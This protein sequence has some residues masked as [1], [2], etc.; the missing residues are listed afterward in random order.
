MTKD[1]QGPL[2]SPATMFARKI[3]VLLLVGA[4]LNSC[5]AVR[6]EFEQ[7]AF[8]EP[9]FLPQLL[10]DQADRLGRKLVSGGEER[11]VAAER[12]RLDERLDRADIGGEVA[13]VGVEG[14]LRAH[15]GV[16][17]L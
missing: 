10:T 14:G 5:K 11:Y 17:F 4:A 6:D 16:S 2:V 15:E 8:M 3:L 13:V 9:G 7:R 1:F 12:S